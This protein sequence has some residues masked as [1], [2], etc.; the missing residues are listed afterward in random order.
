[1]IEPLQE[2]QAWY[3]RESDYV[4]FRKPSV[5]HIT[6]EEPLSYE[7]EHEAKCGDGDYLAIDD[8]GWDKLKGG[9]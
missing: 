8:Q 9:L 6:N 4:G 7:T 2:D 5:V 3:D 1:M